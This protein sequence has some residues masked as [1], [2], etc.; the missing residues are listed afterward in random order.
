MCRHRHRHRRR[1]HRRRGR[2]LPSCVVF[3]CCRW[4]GLCRGDRRRG[5]CWLLES[6]THQVVFHGVQFQAVLCRKARAVNH[7][8]GQHQKGT[9]ETMTQHMGPLQNAR[10]MKDVRLKASRLH[11]FGPLRE[12][13]VT[14]CFPIV[15]SEHTTPP[16][17]HHTNIHTTPHH[18]HAHTPHNTQS[19][20]SVL[21]GLRLRLQVGASRCY[22]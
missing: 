20:N 1:R 2:G 17:T 8:D 11:S 14:R 4:F 13:L 6:A 10:P 9:S 18:T 3:P 15:V 21:G 5:S 16:C 19:H 22:R 12:D 7:G